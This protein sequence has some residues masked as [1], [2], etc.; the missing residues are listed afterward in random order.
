MFAFGSLF[1][2]GAVAGS[3]R[4]VRLPLCWGESFL[5]ILVSKDGGLQAL[6]LGDGLFVSLVQHVP[7]QVGE[8]LD[9]KGVEVIIKQLLQLVFHEGKW[10]RALLV[11]K[12]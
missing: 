3:G 7:I 4:V 6:Q 11:P 2:P 9:V 10:V 1:L 12:A 5:N 8:F